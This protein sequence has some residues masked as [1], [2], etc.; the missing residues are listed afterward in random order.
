MRL[1]V[2][3]R[4]VFDKGAADGSRQDVRLFDACNPLAIATFA[5]KRLVALQTGSAGCFCAGSRSS[6]NAALNA[7]AT[8]PSGTGPP[9]STAPHGA[10]RPCSGQRSLAT[11]KADFLVRAYLLLAV[12]FIL[13]LQS[14]PRE[15]SAQKK[16][17]KPEQ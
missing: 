10:N 14:P 13:E 7:P 1:K 6:C 12:Q 11:P 4:G 3:L 15:T 9:R 2:E 17:Q 5:P 8:L 16:A